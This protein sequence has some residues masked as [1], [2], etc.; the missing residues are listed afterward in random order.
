MDLS[1]DVYI[2][3]QG[4]RDEAEPGSSL[5]C[6]SQEKKGRNNLWMGKKH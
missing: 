4:Q 2:D 5:C 1:A 6:R 3:V